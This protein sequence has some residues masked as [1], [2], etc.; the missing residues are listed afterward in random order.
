L[1]KDTVNAIINGGEQGFM[2]SLTRDVRANAAPIY[3]E[4]LNFLIAEKFITK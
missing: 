2:N 1:A 4:S 3:E